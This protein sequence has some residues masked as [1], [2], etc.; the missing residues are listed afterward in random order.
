M[1]KSLLA[2]LSIGSLADQLARVAGWSPEGRAV[3]ISGVEGPAAEMFEGL[4]VTV[5]SVEETVMMVVTDRTHSSVWAD[6]SQLRLTARHRGWTP[7]SL[8]LRP[9]AVIVEAV[10]S[11][12]RP[13]PVAIGMAAILRDR[14]SVT[15]G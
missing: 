11:D 2:T 10:Q 1:A 5:R 7:Y 4:T 13:G 8:C 6:G 3:R 14:N 15:R 9:I 12:G